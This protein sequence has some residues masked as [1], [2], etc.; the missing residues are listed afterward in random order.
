MHLCVIK[1]LNMKQYVRFIGQKNDY[2]FTLDINQNT[3]GVVV[4]YYSIEGR[5]QYRV[6]FENGIDA[7]IDSED[8]EFEN[9]K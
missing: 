2:T 6:I 9:K 8:L 3:V 7:T 5:K 1:L 4:G